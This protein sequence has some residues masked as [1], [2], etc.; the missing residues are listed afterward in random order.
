MT[1]GMASRAQAAC[2]EHA[3][4][5]APSGG[6]VGCPAPLVRTVR[7]RSAPEQGAGTRTPCVQRAKAA[8]RRAAHS[9]QCAVCSVGIACSAVPAVSAAAQPS[10]MRA[11]GSHE[12]SSAAPDSS[13]PTQGWGQGHGWG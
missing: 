8:A 4:V 2:R 9:V 10:S 5:H 13:V 7:R 12:M 1:C 11:T 6:G 3:V